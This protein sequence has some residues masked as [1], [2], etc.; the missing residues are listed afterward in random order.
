MGSH[1][2]LLVAK[3]NLVKEKLERIRKELH[4]SN[5][6]LV[7]EHCDDLKN[8]ID[9][10]TETL[11]QQIE[12]FRSDLF[13]DID[14]FEREL[15]DERNK[16]NERSAQF[17]EKLNVRL[18]KVQDLAESDIDSSLNLMIEQEKKHQAFV[19]NN[20]RV[21]FEKASM[22]FDHNILGRIVVD[23]SEYDFTGAESF[24]NYDFENPERKR[25]ACLTFRSRI[26]RL[27]NGLFVKTQNN[28]K[29]NLSIFILSSDFKIKQE[30]TIFKSGFQLTNYYL[31]S[32]GD[33]IFL[34]IDLYRKKPSKHGNM[35]LVL[36]N[37]LNIMNQTVSIDSEYQ[38][39]R[40][41]SNKDFII[42]LNEEDKLIMFDWCLRDISDRYD[43]LKLSML[44]ENDNCDVIQIKANDQFLLVGLSLGEMRFA[45]RVLDINTLSRV[46]Q[47]EL[48]RNTILSEF[49]VFDDK[50]V[51]VLDYREPPKF[52]LY[53]W[54]NG[55]KVTESYVNANTGGR[56]LILVGCRQN[57]PILFYD[58]QLNDLF[59]ISSQ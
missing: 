42:G 58:F 12:S 17:V 27:E 54:I 39:R 32:S 40:V 59:E 52:V 41:T 8:Q 38:I 50:H 22:R 23:K 30:R 26:S 29:Q 24:E 28:D 34:Y 21:N 35:M 49:D 43:S 57:S 56:P 7:R 15:A 31:D 20:S 36:D 6:L 51:A 3:S 14:A 25:E 1:E 53:N 9:T 5:Q 2:E 16:P 47:F 48:N 55:S 10:Q 44:E 11:I 37:R 45:I 46:S 19:F 18:S 33:R 4:K 13:K